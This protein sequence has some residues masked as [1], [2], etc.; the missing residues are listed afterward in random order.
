MQEKAAADL[1]LVHSFHRLVRDCL[2]SFEMKTYDQ[3]D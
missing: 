2:G 3:T 1:V